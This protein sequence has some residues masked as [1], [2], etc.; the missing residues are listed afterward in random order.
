MNNGLDVL[1]A[2]TITAY[3]GTTAVG[4][5]DWTGALDT[6][7]VEEVTIDNVAIS[8]DTD[9]DI[10]ITSPDDNASNNSVTA[11]VDAGE[12]QQRAFLIASGC[13]PPGSAMG[14]VQ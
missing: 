13:L 1:N 10:E 2:C 9:F 14:L 3:D 7:E 8:A 6:Y 5:F 11:S 4:S 12:H